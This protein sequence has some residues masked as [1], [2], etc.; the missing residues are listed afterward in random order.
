MFHH[1]LGLFFFPAIKQILKSN[2]VFLLALQIEI[3]LL[4]LPPFL[5]SETNTHFSPA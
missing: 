3:V 2:M 4:P 1:L 5:A